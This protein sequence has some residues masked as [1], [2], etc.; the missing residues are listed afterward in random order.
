M[1]A[2]GE[3]FPDCLT[4]APPTPSAG[5]ERQDKSSRTQ[6]KRDGKSQGTAQKLAGRRHSVNPYHMNN[7][8]NTDVK[9]KGRGLWAGDATATEAGLQTQGQGIGG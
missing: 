4:G 7:K 6:E 5:T 3:L 2:A 1:A 8:E 9:G